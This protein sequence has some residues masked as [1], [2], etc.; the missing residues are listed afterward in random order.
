MMSSIVRLL[1]LWISNRITLRVDAS[2]GHRN[3]SRFLFCDSEE[4]LSV[5]IGLRLRRLLRLLVGLGDGDGVKLK[6]CPL[7]ITGACIEGEKHCYNQN[8]VCCHKWVKVVTTSIRMYKLR[9]GY[10]ISKKRSY[11]LVKVN[12]RQHIDFDIGHSPDHST[13][14]HCHVIEEM[15]QHLFCC[16]KAVVS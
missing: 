2:V 10:L 1:I 4:G 14:P 15:A 6:L 13:V 5:T 16:V 3:H 7:N 8:N 11:S 12:K 9:N